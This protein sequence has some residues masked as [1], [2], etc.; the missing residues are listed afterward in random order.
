MPMHSL[1]TDQSEVSQSGDVDNKTSLQTDMVDPEKTKAEFEK[2]QAKILKEILC[3]A[4][5]NSKK[6]ASYNIYRKKTR[7]R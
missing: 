3:Q 5:R 6:S 7:K 1:L 2:K 4:G